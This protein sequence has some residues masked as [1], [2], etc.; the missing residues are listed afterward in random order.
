MQK[1]LRFAVKQ[2]FVLIRLI[3][4]VIVSVCSSMFKWCLVV[5]I[6][7]YVSC[8]FLFI[9]R[10]CERLQPTSLYTL[11]LLCF[12]LRIYGV[13]PRPYSIFSSM[14]W[15]S[16]F[17][18]FLLTFGKCWMQKYMLFAYGY[19]SVSFI[20][21]HPSGLWSPTSDSFVL[22]YFMLSPFPANQA[23]W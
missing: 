10:V 20:R 6:R 2:I 18:V 17:L 4:C 22:F 19:L 23:N 11:Y 9:P 15:L 7:I 8:S 12:H 5:C 16:S 3:R 14:C 1:S 13:T 21:I